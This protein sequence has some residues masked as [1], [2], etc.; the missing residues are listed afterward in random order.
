MTQL[1]TCTNRPQFEITAGNAMSCLRDWHCAPP[2]NTPLYAVDPLRLELAAAREICR[3]KLEEMT[4]V[5]EEAQ[6]RIATL[7]NLQAGKEYIKQD[8]LKEELS[9][10]LERM[11]ADERNLFDTRCNQLHRAQERSKKGLTGALVAGNAF[12]SKSIGPDHRINLTDHDASLIKTLF[13]EKGEAMAR[14]VQGRRL[15]N[16]TREEIFRREKESIPANEARILIEKEIERKSFESIKSDM[17][18]LRNYLISRLE[19]GTDDGNPFERRVTRWSDLETP[20]VE[21]LYGITG[22]DERIREYLETI[23]LEREQIDEIL[24]QLLYDRYIGNTKKRNSRGLFSYI[25]EGIRKIAGGIREFVDSD[26][27]NKNTSIV[28]GLDGRRYI[29]TVGEDGQSIYSPANN[30][31]IEL[32]YNPTESPPDN[33]DPNPGEIIITKDNIHSMRLPFFVDKDGKRVPLTTDYE[34]VRL[35]LVEYYRKTGITEQEANEIIEKDHEIKFDQY[36]VEPTVRGRIHSL[37]NGDNTQTYFYQNHKYNCRGPYEP[38]EENFEGI[39]TV[40][41]NPKLYHL[42]RV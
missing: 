37:F 22:T 10:L 6:P 19:L 13:P 26:G 31:T 41:F 14:T 34:Q 30:P 36:K 25:A 42:T 32:S 29:I 24:P 4:D 20:E 5:S 1:E 39:P 35:A 7:F 3:L 16:G 9:S 23:G 15:K 18:R 40:P 21:N 8:R 38:I 33:T 2:D 12:S 11:T 28:I 17:P 27:R